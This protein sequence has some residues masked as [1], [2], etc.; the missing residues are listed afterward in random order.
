MSVTLVASTQFHSL[1]TVLLCNKTQHGH[2]F[3]KTEIQALNTKVLRLEQGDCE[4][5]EDEGFRCVE[6]YQ[7]VGDD[8]KLITDGESQTR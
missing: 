3:R 6:H 2:G 7:C 4:E 1:D 8:V 5:F